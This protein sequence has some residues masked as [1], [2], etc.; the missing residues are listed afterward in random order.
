MF[1]IALM[2]EEAHRPLLV[3]NVAHSPRIGVPDL[4]VV[5]P[6]P[7]RLVLRSSACLDT[8]SDD[9]DDPTL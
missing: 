2:Y 5:P 4:L 3:M 6:E 1:V 9:L 8:G 7:A